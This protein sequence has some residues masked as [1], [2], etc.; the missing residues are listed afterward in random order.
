[1][2]VPFPDTETLERTARALGTNMFEGFEPTAKLV[3]FYLNWRTGKISESDFL[4]K[5]KE[6]I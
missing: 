2:G 1:M 4:Q 3:Q 5:L 6:A